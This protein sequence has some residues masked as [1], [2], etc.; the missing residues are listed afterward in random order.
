MMII[1]LFRRRHWTLVL[2]LV[3]VPKETVAVSGRTN[4]NKGK[5]ED[6]AANGARLPFNEKRKQVEDHEDH[7]V[8]KKCRIDW[9]RNQQHWNQPLKTVHGRA[10]PSGSPLCFH[11]ALRILLPASFSHFLIYQFDT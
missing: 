4:E 3:V 5:D 8:V 11:Q 6:K 7:M 1:F 2:L 10:G 9:L